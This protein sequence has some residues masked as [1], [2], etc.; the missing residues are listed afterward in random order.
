M[1]DGSRIV[2]NWG[3]GPGEGFPELPK[4]VQL[5]T[6]ATNLALRRGHWVQKK[7]E[8]KCAPVKRIVSCFKS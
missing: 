7:P 6:R 5:L 3:V 8:R 1:V 2:C 4:A